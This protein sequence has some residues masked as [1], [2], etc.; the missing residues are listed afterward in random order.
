MSNQK[1]IVLF[2]TL[3]VVLGTGLI[4]YRVKMPY[5]EAVHHGK[6]YMATLRSTSIGA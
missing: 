3:I 6:S 2:V 4:L 5:K 1:L